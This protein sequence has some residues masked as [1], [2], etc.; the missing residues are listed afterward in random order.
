[1]ASHRL[2]SSKHLYQLASSGQTQFAFQDA[3]IYDS[4]I[5]LL[6]KQEEGLVQTPTLCPRWTFKEYACIDI[7]DLLFPCTCLLGLQPRSPLRR[8]LRKQFKWLRWLKRSPILDILRRL[9]VP[10][11]TTL[12][13]PDEGRAYVTNLSSSLQTHPTSSNA[14]PGFRSPSS[15]QY[16]EDRPLPR[17]RLTRSIHSDT[18]RRLRCILHFGPAGCRV[19]R[20]PNAPSHFKD[21]SH[22][23]EHIYRNRIYCACGTRIKAYRSLGQHAAHCSDTR[24]LVS[25]ANSVWPHGICLTSDVLDAIDVAAP[26]ERSISHAHTVDDQGQRWINIWCIIADFYLH[27]T[28]DLN[29]LTAEIPYPYETP[30]LHLPE[31]Q[32]SA[33][34]MAFT[35]STASDA[36]R[37]AQST[38]STNSGDLNSYAFSTPA[39]HERWRLYPLTHTTYTATSL[40]RS[41]SSNLGYLRPDPSSLQSP[42]LYSREGAAL[43]EQADALLIEPPPE[44]LNFTFDQAQD[45]GDLTNLVHNDWL[46][47]ADDT[48]NDSEHVSRLDQHV[49]T[50][51]ASPNEDPFGAISLQQQPVVSWDSL[52][53]GHAEVRDLDPDQLR[54]LVESMLLSLRHQA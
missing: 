50:S 5:N 36:S 37:S 22:C 17:T 20:N 19:C 38:V 33:T 54:M 35:N 9:A 32:P 45:P 29:W 2:C 53:E 18:T 16:P 13:W 31:S 4:D 26:S 7:L 48:V 40:S 3:Q 10:R 24:G 46:Q 21:L 39:Q 51:F 42:D 27:Q 30:T 43:H 52:I 6:S 12:P 23:R 25:G 41:A 28:W 34:Q 47:D 11:P 49:A 1:M 8:W 44:L 14:R 15:S